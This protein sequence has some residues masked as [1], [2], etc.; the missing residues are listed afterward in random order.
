[1]SPGLLSGDTRRI[2]HRIVLGIPM[3]IINPHDQC[4]HHFDLTVCGCRASGG[5]RPDIAADFNSSS[6]RK[7]RVA[8]AAAR[9]S[10]GIL[11]KGKLALPNWSSQSQLSWCRCCRS[12]VLN[13]RSLLWHSILTLVSSYF[14][15]AAVQCCN[16][17]S[18]QMS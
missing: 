11:R 10:G 12:A 14:A 18:G 17:N 3:A 9:G 5:K 15:T 6:R 7:W 4:A 2:C 13:A 1:M 8:H 16:L